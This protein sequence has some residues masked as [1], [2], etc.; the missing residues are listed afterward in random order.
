MTTLLI[1]TDATRSS[2]KVLPH[3][4]EFA[5]AM[6]LEPVLLAVTDEGD[7]AQDAAPVLRALEAAF[8]E[9]PFDGEIKLVAPEGG[10]KTG[11]TV[12]RTAAELGAAAVA[13]HSVSSGAVRHAV[14]GSVALRVLSQVS[15]PVLVTGPKII[16]E[17]PAGPYTLVIATDASP[18]SDVTVDT[19]V[20]LL[21]RSPV[22]TTLLSVF[23]A[24]IGVGAEPEQ[25][26]RRMAQLEALRAALPAAAAV[27]DPRLGDT[28]GLEKVP[29]AIVRAALLERASAIAIATR[30][31]GPL[32]HLISGSVALGVLQRSPVPVIMARMA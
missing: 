12:A 16:P 11:D 3:A 10:E 4:R 24:E 30:G 27:R 5:A 23:Q 22:P 21:E 31:H 7:G 15:C 1:A 8:P 19:L 13:L 28:D 20:P 32:R 14:R 6:D 18:G 29:T 26:A 9:T 17:P 2:L 25:R